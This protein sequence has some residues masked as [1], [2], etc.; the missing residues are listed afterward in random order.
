MNKKRLNKIEELMP[1]NSCLV[2]PSQ[3]L[4]ARNG[5]VFH[6]YRQDSSFYYL[7]GYEGANCILIF[8]P[9]DSN[10]TILFAPEKNVRKELWDGKMPS[11]S[12]L[13]EKLHVDEVFNIET[14]S[15]KSMEYLMSVD[16]VYYPFFLD[17]VFESQLMS[18]FRKREWKLRWKESPAF[19]NSKSLFS[20]MRL[21]KSNEELELMQKAADISAE[22]HIELAK[23]IRPDVNERE[24]YGVFLYEIM[25]RGAAREAYPA[26]VASGVNTTCLHY[27]KNDQICRSGDW[28]KVDAGAEYEYYA[29]DITRMYPV[30][31]RFSEVQKRLY[32][33]LLEIQKTLVSAVKPGLSLQDLNKQCFS[34][35]T[36]MLIDEKLLTQNK[37]QILEEALYRKYFPHGLSHWLGI[38]VHDVG[39]TKD[40]GLKPGMCFTVEPGIYVSEYDME[41]P[42][43]LRG[44][45]LR[46]EDDIAVTSTGHKVLSEKAPKEINDIEQLIKPG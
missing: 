1:K 16:R 22:A 28:I 44:I 30:N 45:G 7:T 34:L 2:L 3:P 14:F 25:K 19:Y 18:L 15:V 27:V 29:G 6:P 11:L 46:I 38:D 42:E 43:E 35:I 36:E 24:L 10:K 8:L 13:K 20:S 26:I 41:A 21:I 17:T 39:L 32:S 33:R 9:H 4:Q 23:A 37:E 5:D 40:V 12:E 31:G